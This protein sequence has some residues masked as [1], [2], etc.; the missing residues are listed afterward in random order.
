VVFDY[1]ENI[2][3]GIRDDLVL[4]IICVGISLDRIYSHNVRFFWC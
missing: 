2:K 3:R 4:L 1:G